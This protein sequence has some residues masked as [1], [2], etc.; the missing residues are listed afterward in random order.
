MHCTCIELYFLSYE[1]SSVPI[2]RSVFLRDAQLQLPNAAGVRLGSVDAP[3]V[4]TASASPGD[5]ARIQHEAD[6]RLAR[7]DGAHGPTVVPSSFRKVHLQ[8]QD[9]LPEGFRLRKGG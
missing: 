5:E 4:P 1:S 8:E 2:R 7:P 3:S 6:A 9:D